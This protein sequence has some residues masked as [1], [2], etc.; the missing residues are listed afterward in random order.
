M[1]TQDIISIVALVVSIGAGGFSYWTG[2][3]LQVRQQH[4]EIVQNKTQYLTVA[5]MNLVKNV[6][7]INGLMNA[8]V[9]GSVNKDDS[10]KEV[11]E[12]FAESRDVFKGVEDNIGKKLRDSVN[13]RLDVMEDSVFRE[14]Q[15]AKALSGTDFK[16]ILSLPEEFLRV[17]NLELS[18]LQSQE[19]LD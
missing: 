5:K 3:R 17:V 7:K 6:A 11:F 10:L 19:S 8:N 15:N 16:T 4:F 14:F 1:E 12:Q 9:L 2:K 18:N 13:Q